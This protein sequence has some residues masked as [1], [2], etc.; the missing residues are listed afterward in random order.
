MS[1]Q[2]QCQSGVFSSC[3]CITCQS[4]GGYVY[5]G[6]RGGEVVL[7]SSI[8]DLYICLGLVNS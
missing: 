6:L 5:V 8:L 1:V 7:Y 3:F 2:L 4:V